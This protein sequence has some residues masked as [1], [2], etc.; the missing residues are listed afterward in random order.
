M[1]SRSYGSVEPFDRAVKQLRQHFQLLLP[2]QE[3]APARTKKTR[4]KR[5]PPSRRTRQ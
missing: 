4:P 2:P 1:I 5:Q 3:P